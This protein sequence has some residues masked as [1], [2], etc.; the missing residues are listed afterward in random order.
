MINVVVLGY[1]FAG[2]DFHCYLVRQADGLNLYGVCSSSAEKRASAEQ[3]WG[4]KTFSSLEQALQDDNVQ[5]VVLA[6][7]HDVHCEQALQVM[8]AGRHCVTDK[9]MCMN[10]DE[11]NQ[12]VEASQKNDVL[13]SVFHNRR[14]DWD[15]LT[16][17]KV[18][19]EGLIGK[20]FHFESSIM[21]YGK[22][23]GWRAETSHS[24]GLLFDWGAHLLDQALLLVES[25]VRWV[26]CDIQYG[27]WGIDIGNHAKW[28]LKFENETLFQIELSNLSRT[29]LPR[30]RVLGDRGAFLKWGRDP[31]EPAM[32]R[33]DIDG[34]TEPEEHHSRVTTEINGMAC[35]LSIPSVRGSWKSYYQNVSDALNKG[36]ELIVKPEQV[37]RA[38]RVYDATVQSAQKQEVVRVGG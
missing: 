14:W 7:P 2:R 6:T 11:A 32:I 21:G 16:L 10:A 24:G 17:R 25:P 26:F 30:W 28:L 20:P 15:Y 12:M 31:Q 22:P 34:A 38:M 1:G 19:D 8:N 13:L 29:D 9:V 18:I 4:V 36:S 3:R 33:G 23:R 35:D 27:R 5:L 37:A